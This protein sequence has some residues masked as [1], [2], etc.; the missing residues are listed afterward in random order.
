M[1]HSGKVALSE[2]A[3]QAKTL[4]PYS[5]GVLGDRPGDSSVEVEEPFPDVL[6]GGDVGMKARV[7]IKLELESLYFQIGSADVLHDINLVLQQGQLV[8]LMGESGSGKTTLLRSLLMQS[9]QPSLITAW[10]A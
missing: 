5:P 6:A 7:M 4:N 2:L 8:A 1:D 9:R 10:I 3:Q